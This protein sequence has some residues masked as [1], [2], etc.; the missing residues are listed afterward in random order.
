MV[1]GG[2]E[3][4]WRDVRTLE[5]MLGHEWDG[6]VIAVNDVGCHWPRRLHHW[7]SLHAANLPKWKKDRAAAGYDMTLTTWSGTSGKQADK[8]VGAWGGG[9]SGLL[10]VSVATALGC[11]HV[12]LCGVPMEKAPHFHES[13]VH[14][15][16][17]I[18]AAADS[19]WRAWI[20]PSVL[21]RMKHVRSMSGRTG[22]TLGAPTLEWLG[23]EQLAAMGAE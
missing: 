8:H 15:K 4:V 16:G 12:V 17:K 13:K 10:A 18:W 2:A 20:K 7:C 23:V 3:C 22:Q 21:A 19:H 11:A 5:A 1:I 14:Q 6:L 9:S